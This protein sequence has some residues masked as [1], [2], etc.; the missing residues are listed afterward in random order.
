MG[1]YKKS[2][3]KTSLEKGEYVSCL[4]KIE[5]SNSGIGKGRFAQHLSVECTKNFIPSYIQAA[6]K[7][8][9]KR[10]DEV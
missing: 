3:F 5:S 2:N 6:I 9:F 1:Q 4:N 8:I 7:T 10:V